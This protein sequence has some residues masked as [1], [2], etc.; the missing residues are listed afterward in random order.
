MVTRPIFIALATAAALAPI[1][2]EAH[3]FLDRADPRVGSVVTSAPPTLRLRFTQGVVVPF[4]RVTVT[5][6]AGFG[7]A[8]PPHAVA[9]DAR[10]LAVDLKGAAPPGT[11]TVRWRVLSVDTHVTEG[12]FGFQVKP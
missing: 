8:G 12:D 5:G 9:G 10:S 1:A 4:C 3:A 2:A 11:Y 6:P 7:G